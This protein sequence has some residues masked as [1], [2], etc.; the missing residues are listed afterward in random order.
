MNY[1]KAE[2]VIAGSRVSVDYLHSGRW[3]WCVVL[4]GYG[5]EYF[6]QDL[7]QPATGSVTPEA[8]LGSLLNFLSAAGESYS[9]SGREGEN[10]GLFPEPVSQWAANHQD[11]LA[12]AAEGIEP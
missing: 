10:A 7:R 6:D 5:Y 9:R 12:M 11:E 4:D 8:M 2:T 3:E 1:F